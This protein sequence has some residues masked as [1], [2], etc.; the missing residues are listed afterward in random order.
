MGIFNSISA[1]L[2]D[3][4]KSIISMAKSMYNN[5]HNTT[6]YIDIVKNSKGSAS[7]LSPSA[8]NTSSSCLQSPFISESASKISPAEANKLGPQFVQRVKEIA[9]RINCN[10][11]DIMAVMKAES[12]I[13]ATA[14]NKHSGAT[15]LIQFM[16]KTALGLGTTTQA[17]RCMTAL[18]QLDYVEKYLVQ[19]KRAAGFWSGEP[20]SYA[21]VSALVFSPGTAK[22]GSLASRGSKAYA[23]N[24]TLDRNHDGVITS[25]ELCMRA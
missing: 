17:L 19:A 13:K 3:D 7:R 8:T 23:Q 24:A 2:T 10:Y 9:Q 21:Q 11:L 15:G 25:A 5:I 22:R 1:I 6:C 18:Q 12:G 16:P 20:L 14:V 4:S